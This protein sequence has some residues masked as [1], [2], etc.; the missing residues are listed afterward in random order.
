MVLMAEAVSQLVAHF[1]SLSTADLVQI[2][3]MVAILKHLNGRNPSP[4]KFNRPGNNSNQNWILA[5]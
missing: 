5:F 2:F 3:A 1:S 4:S